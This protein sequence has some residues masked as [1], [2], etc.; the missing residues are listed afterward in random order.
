MQLD[1]QIPQPSTPKREELATYIAPSVSHPH[2][3]NTSQRKTPPTMPSPH[4]VVTNLENI[5]QTEEEETT[6]AGSSL[7]NPVNRHRF[8]LSPANPPL[9][10]GRNHGRKRRRGKKKKSWRRGQTSKNEPSAPSVG[11]QSK[12]P[13]S[14]LDKITTPIPRERDRGV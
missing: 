12:Q 10:L 11:N 5:Q 8:D 7:I 14:V 4:R 1:A 3:S 9:W 13:L 6:R 2:F